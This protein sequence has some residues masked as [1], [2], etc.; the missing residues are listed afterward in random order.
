MQKIANIQPSLFVSHGAP[1]ILLSNQE[2]V[3]AMRDYAK[4]LAIP[5]AIVVVSAHWTD[6]PIGITVGSKLSTIHDFSGFHESLYNLEYPANG[7]NEISSDIAQNLHAQGLACHLVERGLDHGA[8]IPLMIMYPEAKI[9]VI[10][11]SLP[12]GS[13]EQ[14]ATLGLAFRPLRQK[15]VL[16][17]GS[18]GS[19]H[20]LGKLGHLTSDWAVQFEQWLLET[21][22]GNH[23]K[24]LIT[25][26]EYPITFHE[27]HPSLEHFAPLVVAWAAGN[28][29]L[30]GRRFHHSFTYGNL[31]MSCFEFRS[32]RKQ[33]CD[34]S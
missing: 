14:L 3:T 2:A 17:I 26:S 5:R 12:R 34:F 9:P 6:E 10:Q 32:S 16:V 21:I 15:G 28:N 20:N 31:G 4:S 18:G 24:R 8:W 30:P 29:N 19:V 33:N 23:F 7:D 11:V 27:A 13:L 22:E 1:D 25:P